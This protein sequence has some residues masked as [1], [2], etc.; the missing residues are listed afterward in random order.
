MRFIKGGEYQDKVIQEAAI[1][2]EFER[3]PASKFWRELSSISITPI[4][5]SGLGK[6][7]TFEFVAPCFET[8]AKN[9]H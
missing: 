8:D 9:K 6:L 3:K 2:G 5:K 7:Y 4:A 1:Y